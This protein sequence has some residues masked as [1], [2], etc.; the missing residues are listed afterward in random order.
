MLDVIFPIQAENLG[1]AKESLESIEEKTDVPVRFIV[2]VDGGT[3]DDH[4]PL[5]A[6]LNGMTS[7][8]VMLHNEQHEYLNACIRDAIPSVRNQ[9]VAL[10]TPDVRIEDNQWF[11]KM[12]QVFAKDPHAFIVDGLPNTPSSTQPP[13]RRDTHRAAQGTRFA[14][15]LSRELLHMGAPVKDAE[16]VTFWSQRA[17][18]SGGSS[19]H[20]PG[21]RFVVTE[22]NEHHTGREKSAERAPFESQALTTPD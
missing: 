8:F 5:K 7:E 16:P 1:L 3:A 6:C 22:S 9:F 13:L 11:G 10:I 15:L 2:V 12:Q 19:W 21:V 18:A 20:A 4:A 14:L 17:M